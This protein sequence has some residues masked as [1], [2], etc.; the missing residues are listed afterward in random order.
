VK[1]HVTE[2]LDKLTLNDR[3]QAAL[4]AVA[5]GLVSP[6]VTEAKTG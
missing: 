4:Y 1:K 5:R 6:G 3:T 2:I